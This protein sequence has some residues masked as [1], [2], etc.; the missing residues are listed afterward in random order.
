MAR[1]CGPL[2]PLPSLMLPVLSQRCVRCDGRRAC[3]GRLETLRRI[4]VAG[5][6]ESD[7]ETE[8][9]ESRAEK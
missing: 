8:R 9:Q 7:W 3:P 5:N 4:R 6:K 2:Y 1:T